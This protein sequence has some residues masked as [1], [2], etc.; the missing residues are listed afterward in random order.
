MRVN[1]TE[2]KKEKLA[3]YEVLYSPSLQSDL[4][5]LASSVLSAIHDGRSQ[6]SE[7]RLK[8]IFVLAQEKTPVFV[9]FYKPFHKQIS[10][11]YEGKFSLGLLLKK[12]IRFLRYARK[13]VSPGSKAEKE[14]GR[15]L[16]AHR[17]GI[18]TLLPLAV[19]VRR[20]YCLCMDS[21]LVFPYDEN[22]VQIDEAFRNEATEEGKRKLL[23]QYA[24]F[25]R[26]IHSAGIYQEDFTV[27]NT[28]VKKEDGHFVFSLIDFERTRI[29]PAPLNFEQTIKNLLKLSNSIGIT[30]KDKLRFLWHY[31]RCRLSDQA[32]RRF[33]EKFNHLEKAYFFHYAEKIKKQCLQA[34]RNYTY[35]AFPKQGIRGYVRKSSA[36]EKDLQFIEKSIQQFPVVK[37]HIE[38]RGVTMGRGPLPND[39]GGT[40]ISMFLVPEAKGIWISSNVLCYSGI[41]S[42]KPL[43]FFDF[44]ESISENCGIVFFKD[45]SSTVEVFQELAKKENAER[46]RL[47]VQMGNLLGRYH[48]HGF[49]SEKLAPN[50][51]LYNQQTGGVLLSPF[52]ESKIHRDLP[53]SKVKDDLLKITSAFNEAGLSIDHKRLFLRA[54]R[55]QHAVSGKIQEEFNHLVTGHP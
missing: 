19:F 46:K 30:D 31:R 52:A 3:E 53:P 40:S 4:T 16:E 34:N 29:L 33:L 5:N 32:G 55:R 10:T 23:E 41:P 37:S 48:R 11:D 50:H 9:K 42:F 21:F 54:Y 51:I 28:L 43:G 14:A 6:I 17:R 13:A 36:D 22:R 2:L 20:K 12:A 26:R 18:L 35:L 27:T 45:S 8:K 39:S 38:S 24:E 1:L 49:Y 25:V 7:N 44:Q 15:I 47:L